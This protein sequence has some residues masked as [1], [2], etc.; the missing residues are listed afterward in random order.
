LLLYGSSSGTQ[1]RAVLWE[2]DGEI[3]DLGTLGGP[4]LTPNL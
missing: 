3:Q 4:T 1:T 2:K